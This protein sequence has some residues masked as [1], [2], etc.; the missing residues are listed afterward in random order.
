MLIGSLLFLFKSLNI[1][2][3]LQEFLLA[4]I[5]IIKWT[6]LAYVLF[7]V[8]KSVILSEFIFPSRATGPYAWAY[9][10]MFLGVIILPQLYWVKRMRTAP[11]RWIIG[12]ALLFT[13]GVFLEEYVMLVTSIHRDYFPDRSISLFDLF[14]GFLLNQLIRVLLFSIF[15]IIVMDIKKRIK[16]NKSDRTEFEEFI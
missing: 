14:S 1:Q 6:A 10:M 8:I 4:A 2:K 12:I 11:W 16:K 7:T 15:A 3:R 9:W 13:S 5:D